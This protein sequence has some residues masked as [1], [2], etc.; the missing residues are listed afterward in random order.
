MD[1]NDFEKERGII[2]YLK[3]CVINYEDYKINIVDILGY[4]DFFFEVECVMKIV[5]I[6]ILLVDV[7]EGLMF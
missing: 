6:V 5:D 2:I 7:S 3:N 1:S 4:S